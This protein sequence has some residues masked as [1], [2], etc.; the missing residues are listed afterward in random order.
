VERLVALGSVRKSV[1]QEQDEALDLI[2][3]SFL[4]PGSSV[5]KLGTAL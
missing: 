2:A 3:F 4:V 1:E 5:Q